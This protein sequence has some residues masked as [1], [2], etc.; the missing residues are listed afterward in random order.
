MEN[1]ER[2]FADTDS[3]MNQLLHILREEH[4]I[5]LIKKEAKSIKEVKTIFTIAEYYLLDYQ[6]AYELLK[7]GVDYSKSENSFYIRRQTPIEELKR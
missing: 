4:Y 3:F 2:S 7:S 6:Y 1:I 5:D